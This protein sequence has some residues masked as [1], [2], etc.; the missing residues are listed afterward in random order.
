MNNPVQA[1][2]RQHIKDGLAQLP[3]KW[4]RTFRLIYGRDNGKRSVEDAETMPIAD[5]VEE[6]PAGKLYWAM[7]QVLNSIKK[8]EVADA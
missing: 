2:A 8:L 1:F 3:E 5:L 7:Q 4:Q 6:I